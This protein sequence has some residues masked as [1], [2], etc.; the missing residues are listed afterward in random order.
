VFDR[1]LV[2]QAW[3]RH[4]LQVRAVDTLLGELIA[5]MRRTGLWDRA[6]LVVMA[7]HGVSFLRG[8]TDRRTIV[9]ANA[10]DIAPIPLFV[11]YPGQGRG[12]IDRSLMRTTDVL[13]TIARRI[14]L[15][16]PRSVTG[17]PASSAAVRRRRS[18]T[19]HSRAPIVR[20]VVSRPALDAMRH[21]ALRRRLAL[22]GAGRRSLFDFGPNRILLRR[23]VASLRVVGGGGVRATLNGAADY[24]NVD[25]RDSFLPAHVTGRIYGRRHG[26]RRNVAVALN[27]VIRGVSRT[28]RVKRVRGELYS[29]LVPENALAPGPNAVEVFTVSRGR[30][31]RL[32]RRIYGRPFVAPA[33]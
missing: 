5:R 27:G 22:F 16:L 9:P 26:S 25:V 24:R 18:V 6:I 4:L 20:I 23:S 33:R 3:Q 1:T 29:V 31:R 14:G 30:G 2:R 28:V 8:A 21:T 32:L 10:R 19:V 12:R 11:K 17:R 15:R 13:P 7:D